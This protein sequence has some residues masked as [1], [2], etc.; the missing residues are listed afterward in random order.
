MRADTTTRPTTIDIHSL[1][2]IGEIGFVFVAV[3][4]AIGSADGTWG[5]FWTGAASV[6]E[7]GV[8]GG[9]GGILGLRL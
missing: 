7:G 3:A 1:A 2:S 4:A 6:G 5:G 9:N 8:C